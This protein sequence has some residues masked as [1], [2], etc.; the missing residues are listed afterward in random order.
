MHKM[1]IAGEFWLRRRGEIPLLSQFKICNNIL[2]PE[3]LVVLYGDNSLGREVR[4][5]FI[6]HIA[7]DFG[8]RHWIR[9]PRRHCSNCGMYLG[10]E[11]GYERPKCERDSKTPVVKWP[12]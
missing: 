3:A 4:I 8:Y 9:F 5:S 1:Y 12:P 11:A 6:L 7:I 2:G 10:R